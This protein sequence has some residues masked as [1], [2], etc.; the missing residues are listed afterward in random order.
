MQAS[1]PELDSADNMTTIAPFAGEFAF[2]CLETDMSTDLP[3][4]SPI[5]FHPMN[6]E[7]PLKAG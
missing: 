3:P 7:T 5:A 2:Y 1:C 6:I 4:V